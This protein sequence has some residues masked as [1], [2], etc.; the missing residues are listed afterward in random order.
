MT[1][2]VW[3]ILCLRNSSFVPYFRQQPNLPTAARRNRKCTECGATAFGRNR[4]SAAESA[5]LSTFGAKTETEAEIR[6]IS[7]D[8]YCCSSLTV[9]LVTVLTV[10]VI[11]IRIFFII[12]PPGGIA[13]RHVCWCVSSLTCV[14]GEISRK[15]AYTM[16]AAAMKTWKTNGVL[17]KNRR[18]Q[19][20]CRLSE[21]MFV[22]LI[23]EPIENGW[24]YRLGYNGAPMGNSICGIE[25]SRD[26]WRH[27]IVAGRW[28][29]ACVAQVALRSR[30]WTTT[31][32]RDRNL[33]FG[34]G[35][36]HGPQ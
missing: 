26:R 11:F 21:N 19:W 25:W 14:W 15:W 10:R 33:V 18:I 4:M 9:T 6:S 22:A 36:P 1:L 24:R 5:H 17:L 2:C 8:D 16:T 7:I 32:T 28:H 3:R 35:S 29:C 12:F 30:N 23:V 27:V 13:I 31:R 34:R 20:S